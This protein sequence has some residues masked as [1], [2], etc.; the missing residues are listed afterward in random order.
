MTK[1][2]AKGMKSDASIRGEKKKK[3]RR[4]NPNPSKNR[5]FSGR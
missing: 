2:R 5:N 1:A 3:A 4:V